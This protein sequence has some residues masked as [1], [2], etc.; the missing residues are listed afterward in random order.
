MKVT[1]ALYW[2]NNLNK[3]IDFYRNVGL[4]I[5]R[6]TSH[7]A[8][9]ELNG[10]GITLV[11]I[12]DA[13]PEFRPDAQASEKGKGM[14]L[15]VEVMDVDAKHVELKKTGITTATEPRDWEWGNRE[16]IVKDPDGYKLCFWQK[17]KR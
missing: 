12:A 3:S 2:V 17:L 11:P 10:F 16:F 14:Y 6:N 15:Y 13:E 1:N 4:V 8:E 7:Y 5:K 9:L